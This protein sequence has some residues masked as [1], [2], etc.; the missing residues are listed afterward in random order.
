MKIDAH[1]HFWRFDPQRDLWI[2]DAM[3]VLKRDFLPEDLQ[4]I[5]LQNGLDGCI[6]VQAD[7]S[8]KETRFLLDLAGKHQFIKGVVGWLDLCSATIEEQ[9]HH[10]SSYVKLKGL[11]HIV[12]AEPDGFMQREDFQRGVAAMGAYDLS[13]DILIYPHQ[14]NDAIQLAA[15]FPNQRFIVDHCAK[16]EIESGEIKA[17][18]AGIEK[19]AAFDNV[20]CKLSG[21]ITE[22]DWKTWNKTDLHPYLDV[23]FDAFGSG[24]LLFG[25]DWPVCLLAGNYKDWVNVVENYI[26]NRPK[27]EQQQVMGHNA[28]QWYQLND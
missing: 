24:R 28:I 17:W 6:A 22:A 1:Q 4:P 8:E 14:L 18:Q 5:L 2:T 10:F 16:P 7:T 15:K 3:A 12:Q 11:R 27:T 20:A 25:S 13:Y 21:L 26:A 9:L 19:L 23:A